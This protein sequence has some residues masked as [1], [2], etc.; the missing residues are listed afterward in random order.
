MVLR[1]LFALFLLSGT[2]GLIYQVIWVR[3][4]G[5]IFGNTIHSA[6]VVTATFMLGLGVG[7]YVAGRW[8]DRQDDPVTPLK[9]YGYVEGAIAAWGLILAVVFQQ[10]ESLSGALTWYEVGEQGW[11]F[12]TTGSVL[13]RVAVAL[14]MLAPPTLL[15][16]ATLTLLIRFL[17]LRHLD[18]AGWRIGMLY[19]LN[20]LGA[21]IG[22][23][24]TDLLLIPNVGVFSTQAVAA[25]ANLIAAL[26]A[27]RLVGL[28]GDA[29]PHQV[30]PAG[31]EVGSRLRSG[32]IA[33]ALA[34][35]GFAGMGFEILW[36]RF[37]S[38]LLLQLRSVFSILLA[39]VLIGI[40]AGSLFGGWLH[41]RFGRAATFYVIGQMLLAVAAVAGLLS[42]DK[43]SVLHRFWEVRH[44]SFDA[45]AGAWR[46]V[47]WATLA[48][49]ST[50][51]FVPAVAMGMSFPLANATIQDLES[52][53]GRRAGLLYLANTTGA[54]A[55]SLVVGLWW[56]PVIGQQASVL[57]LLAVVGAG[58]LSYG[59]GAWPE[60]DRS[61]RI[62]APA[63]VVV[64]GIVASGWAT[65]PADQL[66]RQTFLHLT[67]DRYR[68]LSTSEGVYESILIAEAPEG[69]ALIT[70]GYS[71]SATS[72]ISQRY[73]RAFAHVPLLQLQEPRHVL[74]ICFGVGN[75]AH[76]ASLHPID[77]LEVVDLSSDVLE[78]ASFFA[79]VNR[80][81][82]SSEKVKVFVNDGRSH[83]ASGSGPLYDLVT[84]EPPPINQVGVA[85]LYTTDY[86]ELVKGRLSEGGFV[87]QWLPAYQVVPEVQ[88]GVIKSF[89]DA[90]PNGVLLVGA[91]QEL[92]LIG[93][94]GGP[95]QLDPEQ[96]AR[97]M[98]ARPEVSADLARIGIRSVADLVAM[99]A[100][101]PSTLKKLTGASWSVT[102]DFPI[103]EYG[104][105]T[106][107]RK[108]LE[109]G[110]FQP[111]LIDEWCPACRVEGEDA[112]V[113]RGLSER[114]ARS[115]AEYRTARFLGLLN[116]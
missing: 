60:R 20:T 23:F 27:L 56:L 112:A 8:A 43:Q 98:E 34:F 77:R 9:A 47:W 16:G 63:T 108:P 15:M 21:A 38:G 35:A 76:A 104:Y 71:M 65:L 30:A 102:D 106:F 109:P 13:A 61:L 18:L 45:G 39:V 49:I 107:R 97:A 91:A 59:V 94:K 84:M 10:M 103:L 101:G 53:I 24:A 48:P 46:V 5:N 28:A 85:S 22:A 67:N 100:S 68:V 113:V 14:L 42:V 51:A 72:D 111:E 50:I 2:S 89:L 41:R 62:A 83:L 93:Q 32:G 44:A 11:H 19:G 82:L 64:V 6:S 54:V 58:V 37:S 88:I 116:R 26:G 69:R 4:F 78:H 114:L 81:V 95:N 86:Y 73:M 12:L 66:L 75:T 3:V 36:F 33:V 70:N 1:S 55:G 7:S 25:S 31:G 90:F 80:D 99:Y 87:T 79:D 74:V 52:A 29:A 40:F 115:A 17:L 105:P 57:A 92:I 96:V 110:M